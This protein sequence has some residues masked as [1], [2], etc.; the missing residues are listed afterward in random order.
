[1]VFIWGSGRRRRADTAAGPAGVRR[2][3]PDRP[4]RGGGYR[5]GYGGGGGSCLR[6]LLLLDAGCC[7]A[8]S[9][10]C[11]ANLVL[12]RRRPRGTC[13]RPVRGRRSPMTERLIAAV[14]V[15][16]REISPKRKPCCKFSPT[17]LRL[18]R[19][20]AGDARRAAR[21]V[22]DRR[23]G[24]CAAVPG[25]VGRS[26]PGARGRLTSWRRVHRPVRDR[27]TDPAWRDGALAWAAEQL[28]RS[29]LRQTG[30][31]RAAARAGLVDGVAPAGRRRVGVAEVGGA[32][33]R[34]GAGTGGGAG[35][36]DARPRPR[37][38]RGGCRTGGCCCCP[39]A[40][41]RCVLPVERPRST[42]GRGLVQDYARLQL[43]LVPGR[44]GVLALGVP[45][46]R[47]AVL[48]ELVRDL[49]DDDEALLVG[50]P[51]GLTGRVADGGPGRPG[52]LT[53][54]AAADWRRRASR[55]PSSTT[56]CTTRTSSS[57][58]AGTASSTGATPS[59]SHPFLSLLVPLR[60]A[61]QALGVGNG[62]AVL[63]RLRDAYLEPWLALRQPR[64]AAGAVRPGPRARPAAA[65]ADLAADPPGRASAG[66]DRVGGRRPRL[67]RR[68]PR[69]GHP[70]RARG[71][72]GRSSG[73]LRAWPTATIRPV[74]CR[75]PAPSSC[76]RPHWA[77][78]SP[79]RRGRAG[80]A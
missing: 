56:T 78:G 58:T 65:G 17:L 49:L 26:G 50:Q 10:G 66:A 59:V 6:D 74:T 54:T 4:A 14:R 64:R 76:L 60:V 43:E 28:D 45:D 9:I 75:S 23:A 32:W 52:P 33:F 39:T 48:P 12:L 18:R 62:D 11:G 42:R 79:G 16:Q 7:L 70:R 73:R 61:R 57:A 20:G 40:A 34:A 53:P 8:E 27:T 44:T 68:V 21:R 55:R 3:R 22:A 77:G 51:G 25:R 36:V 5:R 24:C 1:M 29:G 41:R 38:A 35:G 63:L 15:Y 46:A 80:R 30:R 2:V 72:A 31:G 47:L 37:S 67:D 71:R 19:R 13:T 69:T